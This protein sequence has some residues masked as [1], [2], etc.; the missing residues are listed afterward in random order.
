MSNI[1]QEYLDNNY[2]F[3]FSA[4]DESQVKVVEEQN[5]LS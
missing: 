2:D 5:A 1:P 3:G 4:V